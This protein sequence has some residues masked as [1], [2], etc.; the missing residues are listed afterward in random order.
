MIMRYEPLRNAPQVFKAMTGM[1]VAQFEALVARVQPLLVEAERARLSRDGR[2]RAIGAGHPFELSPADQILLT[3]VRL[4]HSL[5][6]EV[7][8]Y[9]FGVSKPTA[10]RA[11]SR[12]LPVLEDAGR[13]DGYPSPAS[14]IS[15][16]WSRSRATRGSWPRSPGGSD[17]APSLT[18]IRTGTPST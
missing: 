18:G 5:T 14:L 6:H 8:A 2:V 15:K 7:L 17:Q 13:D 3:V 1:T 4:R 12:I 11:I 9:F 16:A 10:A